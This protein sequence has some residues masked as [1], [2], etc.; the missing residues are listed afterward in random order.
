MVSSDRVVC[1]AVVHI[2]IQSCPPCPFTPVLKLTADTIALS[3]VDYLGA[4]VSGS[5][6]GVTVSTKALECQ[7][8]ESL[9][10]LEVGES[11]GI[12]A[13]VIFNVGRTLG[14]S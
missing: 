7:F 8:S 9:W 6:S 10:K 11:I 14:I 12:I 4:L 2:L 3:T 13:V 5:P 1:K